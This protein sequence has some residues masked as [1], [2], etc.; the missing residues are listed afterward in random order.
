MVVKAGVL[1]L[2][3]ADHPGV[4]V[5]VV[6]DLLVDA[7]VGVVAHVLAPALG[8]GGQ[9]G[10]EPVQLLERQAHAAALAGIRKSAALVISSTSRPLRTGS[11]TGRSEPYTSRSG[12]SAGCHR[13]DHHRPVARCVVERQWVV[14]VDRADRRGR[15]AA[16][17]AAGRRPRASRTGPAAVAARGG[18]AS[19][20]SATPP[21]CR[22]RNW[23][24][25]STRA[26]PTAT[27]ARGKAP[28]VHEQRRRR[29]PVRARAP[30][31]SSPARR[32]RPAPRDGSEIPTQPRAS[33]ASTSAGSGRRMP[34][35]PQ[36]TNWSPSDRTPSRC[37]S[38]NSCAWSGASISIPIGLESATAASSTPSISSNRVAGRG[39]LSGHVDHARRLAGE[40]QYAE[41]VVAADE[42]V[43]VTPG[44]R[45][46]QR[47]SPDVLMDIDAL[48]ASQSNQKR[49]SR[50][51]WLRTASPT[52]PDRRRRR[53]RSTR[54]W[55]T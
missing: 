26:D 20:T 28:G 19:R 4:D 3:P 36:A 40:V 33:T 45:I 39:R 10:R 27:A 53:D 34:I 1:V 11:I 44:E 15:S 14:Q 24:A 43:A 35:G 38:I 8:R 52:M 5:A 12:P 6:P 17:S 46:Q 30:V 31:R 7:G 41:A 25:P 50:S 22:T 13:L 51:T 37:A 48:H 42:R 23:S 2:G 47:C 21:A 16:R 49:L 9:A 29:A 18:R 55:P 32:G 54:S